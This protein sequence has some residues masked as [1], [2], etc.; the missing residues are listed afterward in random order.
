M[1]QE[2]S[3][4]GGAVYLNIEVRRYNGG[5]FDGPTAAEKILNRREHRLMLRQLHKK[6]QMLL[7]K[8]SSAPKKII[9][10]IYESPLIMKTS[11]A[12]PFVSYPSLL[13]VN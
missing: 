6:N 10:F 13:S 9:T 4:G 7:Q 11:T 5:E 8:R 12:T 1:S 3:R 2:D